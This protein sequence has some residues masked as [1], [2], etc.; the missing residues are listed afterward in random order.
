[1]RYRMINCRKRM[2]VNG[3]PIS[4]WVR[5]SAAAFCD[6]PV[7]GVLSSAHRPAREELS[8]VIQQLD[9]AMRGG[10]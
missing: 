10:R 9:F 5:R 2:R 4:N 3:F 8:A 6:G 1:M 7:C